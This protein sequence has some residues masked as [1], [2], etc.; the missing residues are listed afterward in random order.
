MIPEL[1]Q[2]LV[3]G[4]P[5]DPSAVE[6]ILH[7]IMQGRADSV[8]VSGLLVALAARPVEAAILA[9][10]ARVLRAH[11]RSIHPNVRPLVDTCGTGGDGAGSF[12]ISTTAAM[13]LAAA[14]CAVAKHGNRGVSSKVG[15]ADVLEAAGCSLD[16]SPEQATKMLDATG[17]VFLFAPAFHPAMKNVAAVR[18]R[19]GVRTM[20]NLLGPLANPAEAEYQL[21]G[22]YDAGLTR[23]MAGALRELGAKGALVVHCAGLDEIGLHGVTTGH[24]LQGGEIEPFHLDPADYGLAP[25][26]VTELSGGD[27]ETNVGHMRDVLTGETQGPRADVVAINAA[28]AL[29]VAERV[30]SIQDGLDVARELI[31]SGAGLRVLE[32]YAESSQRLAGGGSAGGGA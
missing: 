7:D 5:V 26:S 6:E 28:A 29:F 18:Q 21:L 15:S 17:F 13:V 11:Q 2:T 9:A 22:V 14:G 1:I 31:S 20:F 30:A 32:R 24:R 27:A 3:A 23:V 16:L 10:A 4:D 12:N 8:Q 25:A 19:L